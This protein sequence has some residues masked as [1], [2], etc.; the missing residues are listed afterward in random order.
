MK[1][2]QGSVRV[3]INEYVHAWSEFLFVSLLLIFNSFPQIKHFYYFTY[4]QKRALAIIF[5]SLPYAS[6]L[7]K[8]GIPTL[9]ERR[10]VACAKFVS[11]ITPGNPLHPL[12]H[13]RIIRPSSRYNLRPKA[14]T[15]MATKTDRF[16][17][18]VSVK[19]APALIS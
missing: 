4:L 9:E 14:H 6:A 1:Q 18:L 8:A 7:A 3:K 11:K 12:I 2:I 13:S 15:P 10:D 5:P 16:G 19:Y 17:G